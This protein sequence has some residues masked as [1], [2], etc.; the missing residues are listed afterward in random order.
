MPQNDDSDRAPDKEGVRIIGADEAAEALERDDVARR[1]GSDEPRFGDRP[2]A[3][4]GRRAAADDPVPARR[5]RAARPGGRPSRPR[6][7]ATP[8]L[9][10]W[11]EPPTGEVPRIFAAEDLERRRP[12]PWSAFTS[13]Q[14]RW[15]GEGPRARRRLSTTSPGWPTTRPGSAPSPT[16]TAP[17][18]RTASPSTRTT[19]AG[20]SRT[21]ARRATGLRRRRLAEEVA[22]RPASTRSI[23]SDAAP[24]AGAQRPTTGRRTPAATCPSPSASASAS[25]PSPSSRSRLGPQFAVVLVAAVLAVAAAELFNVL[26][27]AGYQPATLLGVAAVRG[28]AAGGLLARARPGSRSSCSSPWSSGC[29]GTS[30]EPAATTA[31]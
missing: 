20:R 27:Q 5:R 18:R 1:R 19:I 3:P 15:R 7:A 12:R 14:P 16:T 24:V 26:R 23:S 10:H 25:P 11:T 13:G 6:R 9:P 21:G 2:E 4:E 22:A 28:A 31:R 29:C 8:T 17:T 30:S